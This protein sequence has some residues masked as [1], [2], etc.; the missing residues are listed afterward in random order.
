MAAGP[1][2]PEVPGL[3]LPAGS[4]IAAAPAAPAPARSRPKPMDHDRELSIVHPTPH[5]SP[6]QAP[7]CEEGSWNGLEKDFPF[8][9]AVVPRLGLRSLGR[10]SARSRVLEPA[11]GPGS[12][13][14]PCLLPH[15]THGGTA[16][17]TGEPL[18]PSPLLAAAPPSTAPDPGWIFRS[19]EEE[20]TNKHPDPP[21][22]PHCHRRNKTLQRRALE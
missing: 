8:P 6:G 1:V 13:K 5:T 11:G 3:L 19:Y 21:A 18:E 9:L 2:C 22:G 15:P 17:G 16:A 4:G 14:S 10:G 20:Q 7:G 12:S